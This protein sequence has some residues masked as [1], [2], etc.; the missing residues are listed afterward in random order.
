MTQQSKSARR[1][2]RGGWP[3]GKRRHPMGEWPATLE[4]LVALLRDHAR[5]GVVSR[6]VLATAVGV[7]EGTV[8]RWVSGEDVPSPEMQ[9]E[10][11]RWVAKHER[12]TDNAN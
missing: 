8:R 4:R 11:K 10:V 6:N 1:D 12:K 5:R 7:Q 2:G 9:R 3:I